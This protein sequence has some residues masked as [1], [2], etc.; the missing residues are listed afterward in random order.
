MKNFTVAAFA[1]LSIFLLAS[2]GRQQQDT[3]ATLQLKTNPDGAVVSVFGK[4]LCTT[5]WTSKVPAGTYVFR[6]DKPNFKPY[7]EKVSLQPSSTKTVEIQLKPV[8]ASIMITSVPSG[9]KVE[10]EGA[11]IGET[12]VTLKDVPAGQHS[13]ILKR[14]GYVQKSIEWTIEDARPQLFKIEMSSNVGTLRI[15]SKPSGANLSIDGEPRGVTPFNDRIEQ[16]QHKIRMEKEGFAIF[17]QLAT[18]NRDK[19]ANVT[20]TMQVLPGT[21]KVSSTPTG[22]T[23][24]LGDRQCGSTPV[25]VKD[26][27]PGQYK[28]ILEKAGHDRIT[29]DVSI[30]PGQR[31]EIDLSM[32]SNTGGID[33]VANPPGVTVYIDG[34]MAGTT[35]VDP[36]QA[37]FS[38]IFSI[39]NL[40]AG[41]HTVMVA[42]KRAIPDK[43]S[44]EVTVKK[45]KIER[46]PVISLWI[47]NATMKLR[48]GP[49]YTGRLISETDTEALFEPEPGIRQTFKK[50][51]IVMLKR[52]KEQE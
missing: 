41:P 22:A 39:R 4:E 29:S 34:R 49:T 47:A 2:C 51:E 6:F 11:A 35:E 31:L 21:L 30:R 42:H 9:I 10:Y 43:R 37:G 33:L 46:M 27:Q 32:D 50:D 15:D 18:V 12:P 23:V 45:G 38:K 44:F 1:L 36:A 13:A 20:A 48:G 25:E 17:E 52:L 3:R 19:T 24:F 26:L 5:P 7:W 16:G 40:G 8:C 14:A 28:V